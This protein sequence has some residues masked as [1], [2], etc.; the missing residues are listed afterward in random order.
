MISDKLTYVINQSLSI[1]AYLA[2]MFSSLFL[3]LA[4]LME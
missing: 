3:T 2:E 4:F 1:I